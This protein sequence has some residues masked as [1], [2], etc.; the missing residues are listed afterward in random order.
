VH[1]PCSAASG[2]RAQ[3]QGG[4][5]QGTMCAERA[6]AAWRA[7]PC[8]GPDG[9]AR[10]RRTSRRQR[11]PRRL[12]GAGAAARR[13]RRRRPARRCAARARRCWAARCCASGRTAAAGGRRP[14]PAGTRPRPGTAWCTMPARCRRAPAAF[15]EEQPCKMHA[16]AGRRGAQGLEE[17]TP[18][19]FIAER[20]PSARVHREGRWL[21]GRPCP[22]R[23]RRSRRSGT[24][25]ARWAPRSCAC[26]RATR[27]PRRRRRRPS[28]PGCAPVCRR[29][30]AGGLQARLH[31]ALPLAA[32]SRLRALAWAPPGCGTRGRPGRRSVVLPHGSGMR[33]TCAR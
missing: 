5:P 10:A 19:G 23:A 31:A 29:A 3:A 27:C 2:G 15:A 17:Q 25:W 13:R 16:T 18:G 32:R 24:T 26:T 1:W 4:S 12:A 33:P 14:W 8:W 20:R 28:R 9:R 7:P 21:C 30:L 22:A 11:R 6:A